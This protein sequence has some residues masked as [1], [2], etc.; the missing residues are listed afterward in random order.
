MT[1]YAG[2]DISLRSINVCV[3]DDQG[4]VVAEGKTGAEATD[5]VAFLDALDVVITTV[6]LEAAIRHKR[7][8]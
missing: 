1:H 7:R 3:V 8:I 6:G 4:N 5:L 2:L